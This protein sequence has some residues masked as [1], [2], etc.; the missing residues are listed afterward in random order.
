M[1]FDDCREFVEQDIRS[2]RVDNFQVT[3]ETLSRRCEVMLP[4]DLIEN[5]TVLDLGSALGAMGHWCLSNG[6]KSYTGVEIQQ[7]YR[8]T[9]NSILEKYHKNFQLVK[10]IEDISEPHDVVIAAGFLHG[11]FNIIS[12]IEKVCNLS[13][14][15]VIIE[16]MLLQTSS[17]EYIFLSPTVNMINVNNETISTYS[18][19]TTLPTKNALNILMKINGFEIEKDNIIPNITQT[20]NKYGK[21]RFIFRYLKSNDT[22]KVLENEIKNGNLEI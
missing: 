8:D 10:T 11:T 14:Q 21:E 19:Y 17:H 20:K 7:K 1:F 3:S 15:Y 6:A 9:S 5:K 22:V 12:L 2:T 13:K 16:T 18:G 4:K